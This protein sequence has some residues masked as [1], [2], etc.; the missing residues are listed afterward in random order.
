[1]S[2][3]FETTNLNM[4]LTQ[5]GVQA[6]NAPSG[7]VADRIMKVVPVIKD[8]GKYVT[9]DG[10]EARRTAEQTLRAP[11]AVASEIQIAFGSD[12]YS[13]E[14][15]ALRALITPRDLQNVDS[16][17]DLEKK[18]TE[19][20]TGK[21]LL[22]L[23][24]RVNAAIMNTGTFANGAVT[25][26]WNTAGGSGVAIEADLG[27]AKA[28]VR[29]A[30][31]VEANTVII[32]SHIATW[33]KQ[34]ATLRELVKY[35]N[36]NLLINGDLPP[37]I[38]GLDVIVPGA[39]VDEAADG[40]T[41]ASLDNVWD[42]NYVWVGYVTPLD[43]PMQWDNSVGYQFRSSVYGG[44]QINFYKYQDANNRGY[45]VEGRIIQDEKIINAS[46]GYILTGA[47]A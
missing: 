18:I 45:W 15:H 14:E 30:M 1:M 37:R 43:K 22:G 21:L 32:P 7:Y 33:A 17:I 34:D 27:V 8:D 23:E 4:T 35:T 28:A 3:R 31:G 16:P 25:L 38:F 2:S 12:T 42:D 39:V 10:K 41:T 20:L 6:L 29:A 44:G 46:A 40:V 19:T 47:Y 26:K 11:R 5:F 9:F 24:K 36:A 13:V